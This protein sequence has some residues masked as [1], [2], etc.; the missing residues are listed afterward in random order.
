M[1]LSAH[2]LNCEASTNPN[3]VLRALSQDELRRD[4]AGLRLV[5]L[6]D[7]LQWAH[8]NPKTPED[9]IDD[10]DSRALPYGVFLQGHPAGAI[11]VVWG[12]SVDALPSA[13]FIKKLSWAQ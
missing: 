9:V 13:T 6:R 7:E 4:Y 2:A 3:V 10:Y 1:E 8:S 11:R 12:E 5:A